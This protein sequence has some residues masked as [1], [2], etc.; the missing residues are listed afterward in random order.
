VGF[1]FSAQAP[2]PQILQVYRDSVKPAGE[3]TYLEIEKEAA[4]IASSRSQG[5]KSQCGIFEQ[6]PPSEI[7]H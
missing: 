1:A 7:M 2:P 4:R 5:L 6:L 3:A